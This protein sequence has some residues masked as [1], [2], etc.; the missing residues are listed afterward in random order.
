MTIELN[1]P[2]TYRRDGEKGKW[3]MSRI[4]RST[5][6]DTM[7]EEINALRKKGITDFYCNT[8]VD[9]KFKKMEV[10]H[11]AHGISSF[12]NRMFD[13]YGWKTTVEVIYWSEDAQDFKTYT[14]YCA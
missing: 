4:R 2:R 7:I 1:T 6:C 8:W 3:I 5:A 11:T 14:T 10:R 9:G 13:K 12:A